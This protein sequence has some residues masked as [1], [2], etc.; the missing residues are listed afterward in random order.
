MKKIFFSLVLF[1]LFLGLSSMQVSAKKLVK[2]ATIGAVSPSLNDTLSYQQKVDAMR[3]FLDWQIA[4]V[5]HDQPDL[6]VLPEA[7]DRPRGMSSKQQYEYYK[8][9]GNQIQDYLSKIASENSCYIAF[10]T[11][12]KDDSGVWR[13]SCVMLNREGGIAGI[14]DKNFPT[15]GE[16]QRVTA[17]DNVGLINTDFGTVG[18]VICFDLNFKELRER[19]A[20]LKPDLLIYIGMYH[21][22]LDQAQWA[23]SCRSWFVGSVGVSN[24]LSQIRNPFGEVIASSSNHFNYVVSTVNIDCEL[25]HLDHNKVQFKELKKKYGDKVIIHD[26]SE[27][28]VIMITSE[29][30]NISA[31][32]MVKEFDI[33][34]VDHYFDRTRSDRNKQ[35]KT[36]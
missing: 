35:L 12:R 3:D 26:P 15:P 33:E 1:A 14:Y 5:L 22:G 18:C 36:K 9:R 21:G 20:E 4:R 23:Y 30:D 29:D 6:I 24:L 11:K 28:A 2:I 25:A 10:G 27:V 17:S 8:V 32:D 34:T 16:M 31:E 19:Y 13:N 7:C